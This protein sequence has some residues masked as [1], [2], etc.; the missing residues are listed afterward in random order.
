[1]KQQL[2]K[3]TMSVLLS[4]VIATSA[5]TIAVPT[6]SAIEIPTST[7]NL[8]TAAVKRVGGMVFT[9]ITNYC[10]NNKDEIPVLGSL[11][12]FFLTN[13]DQKR[14]IEMKGEIDEILSKVTTIETGM[15]EALEDLD[16]IYK[17]LSENNSQLKYDTAKSRV[18]E[19]NIDAP[20]TKGYQSLWE[21][22]Q[23]LF[24]YLGKT[25]E[26]KKSLEGETDPDTIASLNK[27]I[28]FNETK[29]EAAMNTFVKDYES[30][31]GEYSYEQYKLDMNNLSDYICT[32]SKKETEYLPALENMLRVKYPYE[33]QITSQ[34]I[35]GFNYCEVVQYKMYLI[36]KEYASY[37][38]AQKQNEAGT[39]A[40]FPENFFQK[41]TELLKSNIEK[42]IS[43]SGIHTMMV[44]TPVEDEGNTTPYAFDGT[45]EIGG[46]DIPCYIIRDNKDLSYY[47]VTQE[48]QKSGDLVDHWTNCCDVDVYRPSGVLNAEYTDNGEFKMISSLSE[49]SALTQG[50]PLNYFRSKDR[51]NMSKI[52]E[53][54]DQILL[55]N[56]DY[57][58]KSS[59]PLWNSIWNMKFAKTRNYDSNYP[60]KYI[61][62][63]SSKEVYED[64]FKDQTYIKIYK[65]V[66]N[67]QLFANGNKYEI[68][69]HD[70]IPSVISL[71]NGQ[72]LD[73][74]EI[75]V[76]P[77][78]RTI[79]VS[80][81]ATIIGNPNVP[82][83]NSQIIICT[84]EPVAIKDV[85]VKAPKYKSAITVKAKNANIKF[86]G[87]NTFTGNGAA[88]NSNVFSEYDYNSCPVGVSH[89]MLINN[90]AS[91]TLTGST[92]TF[93]G[94]AGGAGICTCGD[95]TIDGATIVANG[96]SQ[97][98]CYPFEKYERTSATVYSVGSGIGASVSYINNQEE[99][100][101]TYKNYG[102]ITIK[103]NANVTACGATPKGTSNCYSQDIGGVTYASSIQAGSLDIKYKYTTINVSGSISDST[104][105][106]SNVLLDSKISIKNNK[107]TKDLFT[108]ETVTAGSS[109]RTDNQLSF[110]INNGNENSTNWI[111]NSKCGNDKGSFTFTV[112]DKY[113]G[114]DIK[115]IDVKISGTDGW[116]PESIKV[117][118]KLGGCSQIFYGG[119][120]LD[121]NKTVTF[122]PDD[123]VFK[124]DVN[125]GD[126]SL[127][128]TDADVYLK[129]IDS[130]GVKSAN[131]ELSS[132]HPLF[133]AFER[134]DNMSAYIYVPDKFDK[135]QYMQ[136]CIDD[137]TYPGGSTW[138]LETIGATQVSGKNNGDSFSI[139][140][141]QWVPADKTMSFGRESGK[142]GTFYFDIKTQNKSG[143]GTD[144]D[145]YFKII[146]TNGETNLVDVETFID[147]YT[148]GNNFEKGDHD[149]GRITFELDT[150]GLGKIKELYIQSQSGGA[151]A[152]WK[153]EY[154]EIT[155]ILPSGETGQHV[156]FNAN[157]T[158]SKNSS[159]TL[160]NPTVY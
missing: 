148:S 137:Y 153:L 157:T 19:Y 139:N 2:L 12:Y 44:T 118:S 16:S 131:Y 4:A 21:D 53:D 154:V 116:F 7:T 108:I 71:H 145:I 62:T 84:D 57:K 85:N 109:G 51:A 76:S 68:N 138:Y 120:W 102:K 127:A 35:E 24:E 42:Q 110:K 133:N 90:N 72:T 112:A 65:S 23:T 32:S 117:T 6:A 140:A 15:Q 29:A 10:I 136:I 129:L 27:T 159:K 37:C 126:V 92:A 1:M 73:Y 132:I 30:V 77:S 144:A 152:A 86:E 75:G 98:I 41:E 158:I 8:A 49:I 128:G 63:I 141:K 146:G 103:N 78:N 36:H 113:I 160:T 93:N 50:N 47:V 31:F 26:A 74:S 67:D 142:S 58:H 104:L 22:Y 28:E 45:I 101:R 124:V 38:E 48:N 96:S 87:T 107:Y 33:H 83:N 56:Y 61:T 100:A 122:K 88:A 114:T 66:Y 79:I 14:D 111:D 3:R 46:E 97:S 156:K 18:D 105:T 69:D 55:Y 95:L 121:D 43:Y 40:C 147:N 123:N 150:K 54:T 25:H 59:F 9:A 119:R 20:Y 64:S 106:L 130:N 5:A 99:K 115:S 82:L 60:D 149:T 94:S 91:V 80:G 125:T 151:S 70:S 155:E 11:C 39:D 135:L 13:N 34:M 52:S 143:A 134:G 81:K 89:G 17:E